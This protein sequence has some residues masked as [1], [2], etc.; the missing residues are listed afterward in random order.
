MYLISSHIAN[1]IVLKLKNSQV[2]KFGTYQPVN[3]PT[4]K[5]LNDHIIEPKNIRTNE[6][7]TELTNERVN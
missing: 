3:E 6:I 2:N 1:A 5:P 4:N 7:K